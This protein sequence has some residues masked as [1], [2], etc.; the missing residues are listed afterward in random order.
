MTTIMKE[1]EVMEI[2]TQL[3]KNMKMKLEQLTLPV[4]EDLSYQVACKLFADEDWKRASTVGITVSKRPEVDTFQL[5]RKAWEQGKRVV[6][7]K[8]VPREKELDF[9]TLTRFSQLEMVYSQLYEPKVTATEPVTSQQIDLLI[10]PG[11]VFSTSG[12]RIGFGGGYYDRFLK[13]FTGNTLSLAFQIQV[14]QDLPIEDHDLPV[15]KIITN[16]GTIVCGN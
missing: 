7:P 1:A 5:I 15:A 13:D 9:R 4:Y 12:Y 3:R 6:V 14:T 11:L 8:C 16:E 10:V 2:K